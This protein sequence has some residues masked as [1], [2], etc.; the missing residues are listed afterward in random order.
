MYKTK[1]TL[2]I[3]LN[4]ITIIALLNYTII[5]QTMK[6]KTIDHLINYGGV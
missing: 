6:K 1:S 3:W 2:I 5:Y 4:K